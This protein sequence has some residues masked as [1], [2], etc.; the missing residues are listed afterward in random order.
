MHVHNLVPP[1]LSKGGFPKKVPLPPP[2]AGKRKGTKGEQRKY[3]PP[4]A[5][6]SAPIIAPVTQLAMG[7]V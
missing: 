5:A 1:L 6:P 4:W 7:L 2:E 3:I